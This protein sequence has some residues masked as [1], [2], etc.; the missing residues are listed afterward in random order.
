M[1][2]VSNRIEIVFVPIGS[3]STNPWNPNRMDPDKRKTLRREIKKNGFVSPILVRP[4]QEGYQVVDGEHRYIIATELGLSEVPCVVEN[5]DDT[6]ARLKTLQLNGLRGEN[7]P[8]KLARLLKHLAY[9]M[10]PEELARKL[11][12]S[13]IEI[14]QML[15]MVAEKAGRAVDHARQSFADNG[16]E[17]FAVVVRSEQKEKIREAL[18]RTKAELSIDNNG[19][20][21]AE[22]CK[23][24]MQ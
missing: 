12:W 19:D 10:D 13:E 4:R 8:D 3:I 9:T 20:A 16:L 24:S 22:L 21:L 17:V 15:D 5:L 23:R 18:D 2:S 7:D 1:E 14:N 11:P 6:E